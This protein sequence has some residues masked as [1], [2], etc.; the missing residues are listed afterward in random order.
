MYPV[1][2]NKNVFGHTSGGLID[3]LEELACAGGTLE[4]RS[5]WVIDRVGSGQYQREVTLTAETGWVNFVVAWVGLLFHT[6]Q[7]IAHFTGRTG[8]VTL[9]IP[10]LCG[11]SPVSPGV[12]I[13]LLNFSKCHGYFTSRALRLKLFQLFQELISVKHP[14]IDI[15]FFQYLHFGGFSLLVFYGGYFCHDFVSFKLGQTFQIHDSSLN[16]SLGFYEN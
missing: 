8:H 10:V 16:V 6:S 4:I 13:G 3:Q 12:T 11:T 15:P 7:I 5:F 1:S 2:V 9:G 14:H